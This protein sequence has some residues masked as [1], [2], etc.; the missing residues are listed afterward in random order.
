[1]NIVNDVKYAITGK[2]FKD[3]DE[4]EFQKFCLDNFSFDYLKYLDGKLNKSFVFTD[5][6]RLSDYGDQMVGFI[7]YEKAPNGCLSINQ[8][9]VIEQHRN[10]EV[11]QFLV[12]DMIKRLKEIGVGKFGDLTAYL[13]FDETYIE[14]QQMNWFLDIGFEKT[15]IKRKNR[16]DNTLSTMLTYLIDFQESPK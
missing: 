7:T 3:Q 8:L 12:S 4:I 16:K 15:S 5:V 13:F 10:K 6:V 2:S 1:M 11:I 14:Q 9:H